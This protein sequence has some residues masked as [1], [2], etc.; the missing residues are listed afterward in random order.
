MSDE[1]DTYSRVNRFD[2]RRKSTKMISTLLVL[3][4]ILVVLF[5]GIIIFGGGEEEQEASNENTNEKTDAP[6]DTEGEQ[7]DAEAKSE[8]PAASEGLNEEEQEST[9]SS[10]DTEAAIQELDTPQDENVIRAYTG[11]WKP[12]GTPKEGPY[13]FP[14]Q[15]SQDWKEMMD[16]VSLATNLSKDNMI[17][18]WVTNGGEHSVVATVTNKAQTENYRVYVT[19]IENKG[20]KPT[21]VEVLREN[22]QKDRFKDDSEETTDSSEEEN[23]TSTNEEASATE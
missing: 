23:N 21:K 9:T 11:D 15:D 7:E 14:N 16:A 6:A 18:W 3:G 17:Q 19:W 20:W 5:L 12:V 8:D 22:D 1:Y 10:E 4:G 13:Q 2:K